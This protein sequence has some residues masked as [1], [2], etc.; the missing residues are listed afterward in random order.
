M[1]ANTK[2]VFYVRY[3]ANPIF[4]ELLGARPDIR[5]DRL[6]NESSEQVVVPILAAAHAFQIGAARVF[7]ASLQVAQTFRGSRSTASREPQFLCE[8][9]TPSPGA[10]ARAARG[11]RRTGPG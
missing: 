4:A 11:C 2:R 7:P 9:L 1:P 3:L 8:P 6:E 10:A 5:L